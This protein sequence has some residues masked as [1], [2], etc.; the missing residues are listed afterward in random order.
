[1]LRLTAFALRRLLLPFG[2]PDF[3]KV[4][5]AALESMSTMMYST[6]HKTYAA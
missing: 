2:N 6:N 1:M 3:F 4:D 5:V